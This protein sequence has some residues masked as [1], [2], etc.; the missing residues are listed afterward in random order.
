[1]SI[2]HSSLE[3]AGPADAEEIN[4]ASFAQELELRHAAVIEALA[5]M[6]LATESERPDRETFANARWKLSNASLM[7]RTLCRRIYACFPG[8]LNERESATIERLRS[9]D[10]ELMARSMRHV[11]KWN[12]AAIEANWAEYCTASRDLRAAMRQSISEEKF[13]LCPLLHRLSRRPSPL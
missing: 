13:A 8:L 5:T 7:R 11:S 12:A 3:S 2:N 9:A 6:K 4:F 10:Q 1:M